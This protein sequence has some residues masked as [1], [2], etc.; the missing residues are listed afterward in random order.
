MLNVNA[1]N[2]VALS[3][4]AAALASTTGAD[5]TPDSRVPEHPSPYA[6]QRDVS[7]T[8]LLPEEVTALEGGKGM[9]QALP[10]EV[11]GYPGP[12]HVLEAVSDGT[13]DLR[14]EQHRDIQA[15]YDRMSGAA[16]EKGKEILESEAVLARRFRHRH[17]DE[18]A[19]SDLTAEIAGLR[20]ELRAIHLLAHLETTAVL[21]PEQIADYQTLRGYHQG[22]G[23][24]HSHHPGH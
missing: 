12:L 22:T 6:G 24:D 17:I 1:R 16:I 20:G 23:G 5:S 7:V 19:V 14:P 9:A 2:L 8:G 10:A 15:T 21:T 18:A 3:L 11:N 13:L 4:I